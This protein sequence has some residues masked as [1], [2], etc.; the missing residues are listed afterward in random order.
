MDITV[1]SGNPFAP[2]VYITYYTSKLDKPSN[3][4]DA[5][6]KMK[7]VKLDDETDIKKTLRKLLVNMDICTVTGLPEAPSNLL[8]YS[9]RYISSEI[10]RIDTRA[11]SA[12]EGITG[13]E[14]PSKLLDSL[15]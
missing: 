2:I 8:L 7:R 5:L 6:C 15:L 12:K 13:Q 4:Q 11:Y 3:I 14:E 1:L 10:H 9:H